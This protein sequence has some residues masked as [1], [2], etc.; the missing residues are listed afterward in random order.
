M[1]G[2]LSP[3]ALLLICWSVTL[4][5]TAATLLLPETFDLVRLFMHRELL[6]LQAFSLIG[7]VWIGVGMLAFVIGDLAARHSLP[8]PRRQR[9]S[10]PGSNMATLVFWT[11]LVLL[12]VTG[13][14][15]VTAAARVGG[16]AALVNLAY[17][18]SLGARSVL[19]E[20][21][22]FDGMRL[23]YA[24]LPATG[25]LATAMLVSSRRL[26][27][28][29][30]R[31]CGSVLGLNLVALLVLP[32]VMS[33]RL[34]LLQLLL[35]AYFA[36][37]LLHDRI[38]GL[39]WLI[40]AAGAFLTTWI[41]RESL[42]NPTLTRSALDLGLQKLAYYFV[43]DMW[44]GI[45][46]LRAE[47][48]HTWGAV[49]FRGVFFLTGLDGLMGDVLVPRLA[50]LEEVRGGGDFPFFTALFIDFGMGGATVALVLCGFAFR[51]L[52]HKGRSSL[53]WAAIYAQLAAAL[54]FSSH[55]IYFTHQNF[56]FSI[57]LT[58][59][60]LRLSRRW[61]RSGRLPAPRLIPALNMRGGTGP[62][63]PA[64]AQPGPA[65]G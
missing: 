24:A 41:L 53:G 29:D 20:S 36:A 45:A 13:I 28:R 58:V 30:R 60:L 61:R 15:I 4:I 64:H 10:P 51:I 43:N 46:P 3:P 21:K 5:V 1:I 19:L 65:H 48:A 34:L 2:L 16:I 63:S 18:D 31:L 32:L 59:C 11:N 42:T 23:F 33:Q 6:D 47:I 37:C 44:N 56:L 40:L 54:T 62:T 7:A 12:C 49:A 14:W 50:A 39:K 38:V 55:G 17:A 22:L 35:S 57:L 9:G 52:F 27:R 25:C 26:P 8:A